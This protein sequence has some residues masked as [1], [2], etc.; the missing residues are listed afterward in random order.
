MCVCVCVVQRSVSRRLLCSQKS[1]TR[2]GEFCGKNLKPLVIFQQSHFELSHFI[3]PQ[4]PHLKS[5]T[6]NYYVY[7]NVPLSCLTLLFCF[8]LSLTK[9]VL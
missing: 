1:Q 8:D 3:C 9:S 5:H 2:A 6:I 4:V 7:I